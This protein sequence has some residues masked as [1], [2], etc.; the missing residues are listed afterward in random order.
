M[1]TISTNNRRTSLVALRHQPKAYFHVSPCSGYGFQKCLEL[2]CS[3]FFDG[4]IDYK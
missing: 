2:L 1:G 3:E 4:I